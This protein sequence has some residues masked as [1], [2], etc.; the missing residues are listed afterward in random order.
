MSVFFQ[1]LLRGGPIT[2]IIFAFGLVS[3]VFIFERILHYHRAQ[4]NV[5]EF[6]RGVVN[7]LTKNNFVEAI[8]ICDETPG[9]VSSILKAAILRSNKGEQAMHQAVAEA[10]LAEIPRLEKNLKAIATIAHIAPLLGLLGTVIGMVTIFQSMEQSGTFVD[11]RTLAEGI[12]KAL[13]S[14][15]AGLTVAIPCHGFYNYF[16]GRIDNFI[17]DMEK[18]AAE[19]INFLLENKLAIEHRGLEINGTKEKP[20]TVSAR[21]N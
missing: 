16:V 1:L 17:V 8:T 19:I 18:A 2:W 11:T 9:P 5:P 21:S 6:M 7:V 10:S 12:W 15:A 3:A 14:T 13:L 4:I 20:T